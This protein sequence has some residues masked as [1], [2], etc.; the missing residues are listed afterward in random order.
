[1]N[2][3]RPRRVTARPATRTTLALLAA[4]VLATDC[5]SADRSSGP[6]PEEYLG[7]W[8]Y[9]ASHS[10]GAGSPLTIEF[11]IKQG[12]P[13]EHMARQKVWVGDSQCQEDYTLKSPGPPLVLTPIPGPGCGE[14]ELTLVVD[15]S[16]LEV[17]TPGDLNPQRLEKTTDKAP[18]LD[19]PRTE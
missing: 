7:V 4:V 11:S 13:G 2:S 18:E 14:S 10:V 9:K 16:L 5:T 8:D 6:V 17:Q 3:H 19:G 1:M 12:R 15:G